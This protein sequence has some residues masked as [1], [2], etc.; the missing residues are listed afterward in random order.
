MLVVVWPAS[1]V[2]L[3]PIIL[4]EALVAV[5]IFRIGFG[6]CFKVSAVANLV[7]TLV[8]I[9]LTWALLVI[10]ELCT[11][12]GYARGL[13]TPLLRLAAVT[14]QAPWLIPYE[15][16]LQWM[17]PAAAAFLC[18]PF[19]FASVLAEYLVARRFF[20][21]ELR[22]KAKH[23]AWMANLY[24]YGLIFVLLAVLAILAMRR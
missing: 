12:A 10:F 15:E 11:G 21:A 22:P 9:P 8:G 4:V 24:S 6:R 1:W 18:I 14:M 2:L 17:V 13:H 20:P 16:S 7:S 5:R 23:W 19:F 3:V